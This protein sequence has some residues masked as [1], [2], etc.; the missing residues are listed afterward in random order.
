MDRLGV[1]GAFLDPPYA[2]NIERVQA[3]IRGEKPKD[4]KSSNRASKLYSGDDSQDIDELV[5]EVNHWCQKWGK[6][7]KVRIALCGYEGEHDNLEAMGWTVESWKAQGG[8]ANRN[9]DN[10]NKN[11]ER[12]WF[13][14]ACLREASLFYFNMEDSQ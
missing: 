14:P 9:V 2:K 8:Y 6:N 3:I 13:S 1:T 12:I 11:R 4:A 5:A 7:S 10:D